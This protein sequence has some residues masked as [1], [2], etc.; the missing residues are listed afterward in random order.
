[1][2]ANDYS[3][4]IA[5]SHGKFPKIAVDNPAGRQRHAGEPS[6]MAIGLRATCRGND[7]AVRA[8]RLTLAARL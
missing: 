3:G 2:N 1:M 8:N 6:Q 7:F 4:P 5:E